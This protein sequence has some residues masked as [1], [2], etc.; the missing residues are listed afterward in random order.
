MVEKRKVVVERQ[1]VMVDNLRA[2]EDKSTIMVENQ[3][4]DAQFFNIRYI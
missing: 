1:R 4:N 2:M 3:M